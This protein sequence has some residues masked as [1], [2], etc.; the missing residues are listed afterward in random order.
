MNTETTTDPA[1][2]SSN[3]LSNTAQK[4][5]EPARVGLNAAARMTG[6]SKNT[7]IKYAE[8]GKLSFEFNGAQKKVYQ[9]AELQRVFGNLKVQ[10]SSEVDQQNQDEPHEIPAKTTLEVAVLREKLRHAEELNQL[11][12]KQAEEAK[13]NAEKW[14][15]QAE[16]ATLM[17]THRPEPEAATQP[18]Q[19]GFL[20]RL[21]GGNG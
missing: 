20:A 13:E 12:I 16:R 21:F 17:L 3:D 18:V 10:S 5:T 2:K 9:V 8:E 15:I 11:Y 7:I 1:Q 6:A 4:M 19:K 14:Q